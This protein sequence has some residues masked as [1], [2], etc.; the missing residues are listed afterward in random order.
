MPTLTRS[1]RAARVEAPVPVEL[2]VLLRLLG[3]WTPLVVVR[4]APPLSKCV[5]VKWNRHVQSLD[6][7]SVRGSEQKLRGI[8]WTQHKVVNNGVAS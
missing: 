6:D 7:V 1:S 2:R 8:A 3:V 4:G 5:S